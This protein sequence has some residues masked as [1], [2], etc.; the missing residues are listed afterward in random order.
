MKQKKRIIF[1]FILILNLGVATVT[2]CG[3][4]GFGD[5]A[6]WKEEVLLHDGRKIVVERWQKHGGRHEPGQE[7]G[8]KDHSITF[9][10]PGT[11]QTITWKDEYSKEIG[12][13]NF[14]LV[15]MHVSDRIPYLITTADGCLAYNKWGRPN[16]PYI[17]F[18]YEGNVWKRIYLQELPI[19]FKNINLVIN[20]MAHEE[21]LVNMGLAS[22]EKVKELNSSLTQ[23]EYKTIVRT[24][25]NPGALGVSCPDWGSSRWTSPKAPSQNSPK[26]KGMEKQ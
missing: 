10:I 9:T 1:L 23:A 26:R 13:S 15:A 11:K 17:I 4:M 5:T 19:K 16:P 18:K 12:H 25:L 2:A 8:I 6:K 24:Q 21:E 7:P 3:F 22:A 20:A 14:D